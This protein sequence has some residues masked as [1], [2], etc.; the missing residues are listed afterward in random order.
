MILEIDDVVRKIQMLGDAFGVVDVID[1]AAATL[2]GAGVLQLRQAALI[3]ELH[4][5]ADDGATLLLEERGDGGT[6]HTA[7]HC[8]GGH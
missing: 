6:V 3:P 1:R 5:E 7:A 8:H 4:G 2:R